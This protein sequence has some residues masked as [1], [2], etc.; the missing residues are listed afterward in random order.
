MRRLLLLAVFSLV[1]YQLPA[2]TSGTDDRPLTMDEATLSK[3][4]SQILTRMTDFIAAAPAFYFVAD[5]GNEVLQQDGHLLESDIHLTLTIQRPLRAILR[6]DSPDGE[7]ATLT[8]DGETISV[9]SIIDNM[10]I[11]DTTHQP[12][13][14]NESLDFLA[15]ELGVPR[16]LRYFLSEELTASLSR[17]TTR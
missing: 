16:Q 11:Y 6:I 2:D 14:I 9:N 10:F 7:N 3:K 8:L 4:A 13:D 12:G 15:T 17:V 1:P 5:G